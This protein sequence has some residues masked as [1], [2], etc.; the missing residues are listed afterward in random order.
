M[1]KPKKVKAPKPAKWEMLPLHQFCAM[2]PVT[3]DAINER[4]VADM[5]EN[6]F[7]KRKPIYY[8]KD[9]KGKKWVLDGQNRQLWALRAGVTPIYEEFIGTEAEA[10]KFVI[11][12][13]VNLRSIPFEVR[14]E[15]ADKLANLTHGG[16][17]K[18]GKGSGDPLNEGTTIKDASAEV[19]VSPKSLKRHRQVKKHAI[20][21]VKEAEDISLRDKAA[22]SALPEEEQPEALAEKRKAKAEPKPKKVNS[23]A[24]TVTKYDCVYAHSDF[25]AR[26]RG[27]FEQHKPDKGKV[28]FYRTSPS[29]T[30]A[31]YSMAEKQGLRVIAVFA[32]KTKHPEADDFTNGDHDICLVVSTDE[33]E[34]DMIDYEKSS[35]V[36]TEPKLIKL[37]EAQ[38]GK[39][40]MTLG[41]AK[42]EAWP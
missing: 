30:G 35:V 7:D 15:I 16:D 25:S 34:P 38:G 4:V 27:D 17:R 3:P 21:E 14:L 23:S 29:N 11:R 5:R 20:D 1:S 28:G 8:I 9:E 37:I 22:I 13:N 18:N 36:I 19:G 32:V 33:A 6:G 24:D 10:F 42:M 26:N 40:N 12:S 41:L 31:A 2:F 39:N